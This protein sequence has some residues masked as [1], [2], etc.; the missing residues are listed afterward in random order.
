MKDLHQVKKG[1]K[2]LETAVFLEFELKGAGDR[3]KAFTDLGRAK[4][5]FADAAGLLF[6]KPLGTGSGNGFG[7]MPDFGRYAFL[8]MFESEKSALEFMDGHAYITE[9]KSKSDSYVATVL[10]AVK[11]HGKWNKS[12]AIEKVRDYEEGTSV[13]VLTRATI[14]KS[15]LLQFWKA[16]PDVSRFIYENPSA[17]YQTGIGEYPFFMQATFS[18]WRNRNSLMEAAYGSNAHGQTVRDAREHGWFAE[19]LFAQFH[20]LRLAHCGRRYEKLSESTLP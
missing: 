2:A 20:I 12:S 8:L 9:L 1:E 4:D 16:V 14:R 15:K 7:A 11:A 5:L 19:E 3:W 13:A 10:Q 6:F 17:L 18:I